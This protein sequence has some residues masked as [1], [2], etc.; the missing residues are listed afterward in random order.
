MVHEI[1]FIWVPNF[2]PSFNWYG[3]RR[4]ITD[5]L[6]VIFQVS[7]WRCR[8]EWCRGC[9]LSE[10]T[11]DCTGNY[12]KCKCPFLLLLQLEIRGE[13][14]RG[15]RVSGSTL[16][17]VVHYVGTKFKTE[18]SVA[19]HIGY[20]L[21]CTNCDSCHRIKVKWHMRS[22][23]LQFYSFGNYTLQGPV[24]VRMAKIAISKGFEVDLATGL[25]IEQQCY[26]QVGLSNFKQF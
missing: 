8:S 12:T 7:K 21:V 22:Q 3:E 24:G 2:V 16:L 1:R 25:S 11:S 10:S 15:V 17:L 26:A 14:G 18:I 4:D 5:T 9:S 20:T 6:I 19:P 13:T 23:K